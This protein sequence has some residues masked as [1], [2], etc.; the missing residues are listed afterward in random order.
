MENL[1]YEEY[2]LYIGRYQSPHMGHMTI[3]NQSLE[4]GEKICIAIRN[5]KPDEKN[6]L[7]AE[8]VKGLWEKV[9]EGNENVQIIIIPNIKSVKYGRGVG[10]SVEEIIVSNDIANISATEIRR[11]VRESET[12]WKQMVDPKIHEDIVKLLS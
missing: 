10:Y 7:T 4:K 12:E 3:F 8:Q 9:Y 1:N 2:N 5:V 6:P 11:Q